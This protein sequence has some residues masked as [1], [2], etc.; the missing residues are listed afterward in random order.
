MLKVK[1]NR[2]KLI[3]AGQVRREYTARWL[4]PRAEALP[5]LTAIK[6]AGYKIGLIS[7]CTAETPKIWE[8]TTLAPLFDVT[9]FSCVV[10]IK[11]PNP[12]IYLMASDKLGVRPT[13]CLYIGDGSSREL[14]GALGLGMHPVLIRDAN[15]AADAHYIDREYDWR[16]PIITSLKEVLNLLGD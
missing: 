5:V 11:K 6:K 12:R 13:D 8:S 14:S 15:D 1:T 16:G 10:G 4:N 3:Q 2:D 9:I 7:D